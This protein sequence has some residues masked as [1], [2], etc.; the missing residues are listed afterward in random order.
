[1]F[2]ELQEPQ[3]GQDHHIRKT[4]KDE[5]LTR[6]AFKYLKTMKVS[7]IIKEKFQIWHEILMDQSIFNVCC[8][9]LLQK[10]LIL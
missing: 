3:V 9:K 5:I 4:N 1:M 8:L 7:L 10:S 2:E 6:Q